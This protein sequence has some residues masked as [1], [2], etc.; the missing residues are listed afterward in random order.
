LTGNWRTDGASIK[1][2]PSKQWTHSV[3]RF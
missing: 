3:A 2:C 1:R